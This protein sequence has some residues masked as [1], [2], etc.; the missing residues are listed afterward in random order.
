[1]INWDNAWTAPP[2]WEI[3]RTL[4]FVIEFDPVRATN[5]I[6]GYRASG[7][8]DLDSLDSVARAYCGCLK[9]STRGTPK[10]NV[11]PKD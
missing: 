7:D 4:N 2:A 9:R 1:M 6:A 5:F 11:A 8:L 3:I 10:D